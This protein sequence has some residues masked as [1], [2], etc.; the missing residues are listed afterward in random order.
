MS[1][2]KVI[3]RALIAGLLLAAGTAGAANLLENG[4]FSSSM[5]D[6]STWTY[7]GGWIGA[8][9][10]ASQEYDGTAFAYMGANGGGGAGCYQT[11][12]GQANVPYTVS[13][14]SGVQAWWWPAAEMRL[15]FLDS[16]GDILLEAVTNCAAGITDYNT[17]L[18]WSNYTMTATSPAGTTQ[19]KVELACPNGDGTVWFDNV[20]LT[21]P[22]VYPAIS[23]IYP[24]G[25]T[26]FQPATALSFTASSTA[27][28]IDST[29]I[30]LKINGVDVSSSLVISGTSGDK[31]VV[32]NGITTNKTYSASIQVTDATGLVVTKSFS[33]DT[34][35]TNYYTWEAEDWD[36]N[37]GQFIDNPQTNAYAGLTTAIPLV[38]Y[39]ETS[40]GTNSASWS[41]R[42]WTDPTIPVPQTEATPDLVR[43]QYASATD[44][45]VGWFDAGEWLNYTR[46]FP[47]GLYNVYARM[48]SPGSATFNLSQVTAGLGTTNQTTVSLGNFSEEGGTAWS[49]YNWVPL[50]DASGNLVKLSLGGVATLRLT[51]GGNANAN[52]FMLV[53]ANTKLPA[54]TSLYPDGSVQFQPTNALSFVATSAAGINASSIT[55]TLNVTNVI[56][57]Y[58][59][60]LTSANGLVV[61]G[62]AS[63]R[64]VS[65]A[66][67][68]TNAAY[69]AIISVTDA[70][71]NTV[72]IN[73]KF[74]TYN[75]TLTWE[76]E[77]WDYDGG[78]F[79][80]NPPVDAYNGLEGEA[81]VDYY[82]I[83]HSGNFPYRPLDTM[84][85]DVVSDTPR[86]QYVAAGTNDYAVGY[87]ITNE[88]V[89]YTRTFP[90]GTY[91]VFG[92][93]AAGSGTS[94]LSLGLVTNGAG[95]SSQSTEALGTF[96][97]ADTGGWSTYKFTPVRDQYGN[98]A[99]VTL[100]GQTTLKVQRTT[101]SDANVNFFMLLPANTSLPRISNVTPQGWLQ[102]TNLLQFTATSPTGIATSNVVV[103]LNGV[104]DTNLAFAGSSTSWAVGCTLAPNTVYTAVISLKDL[105][106]LTASATVSFD[107]FCTSNYTWE[108][109]DYDY[110]GG[111]F[112][113]NPQVVGYFGLAGTAGIDFYKAGTGGSEIYRAD[114]VGT[115]VCSDT[116]RP[117]F[118]GVNYIDY[119]VGYTSTGDWWDYT[120]TY[121]TGK[122]YVYLRAARGT[123]GTATMGL[124]KVT[125]GVD[126]TTQ[127][128]NRLGNFTVPY[129]GAWQTF[130]WV[131]LT[132]ANGNL[133]TAALGGQSTLCLTDGGANLNFLT[134]VPA[135]ALN[136]ATA[137][138]SMK[139]SF[140]SQSGFNYTVSYKTNLNDS[141]WTPINT[142]SGDGSVKTITDSMSV[143]ARYYRLQVH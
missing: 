82:D 14:A 55:V 135:V 86:T 103:T 89:N 126:S 13:C 10:T 56:F 53:P 101:G 138:G 105:N 43:I 33:F 142:L 97:V 11:L 102:S 112:L 15:F 57:H 128:T 133:V 59:T 62:T 125:G 73:P 120:R 25:S 64:T 2:C 115:E 35:A 93:F 29:N 61:G 65:Y 42:P 141:V 18:G 48:A 7:G 20:A 108:A 17:G 137:S 46:T 99:Q 95:T 63:A 107:T 3:S 118:D 44:Y 79:I 74:D 109:E 104:A 119:D 134:L 30:A 130:A 45:D 100:N 90:A 87:F 94:Y 19:V 78:L 12:S 96:T 140:G 139:L 28:A 34:F 80:N 32:Y 22:L 124:A 106:G 49:T 8:S 131:P 39:N 60:N 71:N 26:L 6:W 132:D 127:T 83:N 27:A 31:S 75:P 36:F 21:A 110:N 92:R 114:A 50:T 47:T 84:S 69:S 85:A 51:T 143:P 16:S 77:D 54:I 9:T 66:G 72:S 123:S 1:Q 68:V 122:F 23:S 88:W 91:N 81:G 111:L 58:R 52:F 4:D 40:T 117:Q 76:A 67:L 129:T 70:N 37:G 24:D 136:G 38:D 98:L 116:L 41:Y 113:D 121:P 5:A